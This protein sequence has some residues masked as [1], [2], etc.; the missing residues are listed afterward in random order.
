TMLMEADPARLVHRNAFN[1]SAMSVSPE[2]IGAE[3]K[4]HIPGF[5]L[6]YKV[7]PVRQA[8]ADSWPNA[9]DD[10]CARQE[11]DWKP[12]YDLAAMTVDMLEQLQKTSR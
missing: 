11:W 2:E 5:E 9:M 10:G 12:D 6:T 8:I 7:D 1:I 4:K 3:I